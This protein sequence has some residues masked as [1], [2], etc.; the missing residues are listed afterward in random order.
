[1]VCV[2][3]PLW[4]KRLLALAYFAM[5]RVATAYQSSRY[6][7]VAAVVSFSPRARS[8]APPTRAAPCVVDVPGM[9]KPRRID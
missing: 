1:V 4:K 5:F 6:A 7:M 2:A 9:G 8:Y 3:H